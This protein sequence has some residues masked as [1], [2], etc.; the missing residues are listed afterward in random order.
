M[1]LQGT[2]WKWLAGT[3]DQIDFIK[4]L[5]K[6]DELI[7]NNNKQFIINYKLF[8]EIES[9]SDDF[10]NVF[11]NQ[12]LPLRKHRLRLLTLDL[13]NLIDAITLTKIDVYYTKILNNDDIMEILKHEQKP[14]NIADL[15]DTSVFKTALHKE[16]LI[17]YIKYP[18]IKN[19]CEIYHARAIS[20]I[21][22]KL[23]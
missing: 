5:N 13:Q 10:K 8:K 22:G 6:I 7:E 2:V 11:I 12:D 16:L 3:P 15:M 14:V 9:L 21:D 4:I 1:V 19:R 20:Q 23:L 17:I 18:I